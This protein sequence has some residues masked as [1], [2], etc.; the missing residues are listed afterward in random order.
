[1]LV[2]L[3]LEVVIVDLDR[4]SISF[5]LET[6][7]HLAS[8]TS[9]VGPAEIN[10]DVSFCLLGDVISRD[11]NAVNDS[12]ALEV[13]FDIILSD[14]TDLL[15]VID[16]TL[17]TDLAALFLLLGVVFLIVFL[18]DLLLLKFRGQSSPVLLG[19]RSLDAEGLPHELLA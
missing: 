13:L 15:L 9:F 16:Q 5:D 10:Q 3:L 4:N 8:I 18:V 1:L 6:I 14:L 7:K 17:N 12:I 11:F 19:H 2:Q